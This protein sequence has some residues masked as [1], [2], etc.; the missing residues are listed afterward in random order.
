MTEAFCAA[1]A[2]KVQQAGD[3]VVRC[4]AIPAVAFGHSACEGKS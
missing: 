4:G 2:H 1:L 3:P